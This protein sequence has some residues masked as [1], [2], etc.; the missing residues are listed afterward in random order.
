MP[1]RLEWRGHSSRLEGGIGEGSAETVRVQQK[2]Q[3]HTVRASITHAFRHPLQKRKL[4][5]AVSV[6]M[7]WLSVKSFTP[8]AV[9]P[10][11]CV[12]RAP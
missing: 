6:S 4:G 11:P 7:T 8:C 3:P 12:W 10:L 2:S 9:L 5:L 1:S